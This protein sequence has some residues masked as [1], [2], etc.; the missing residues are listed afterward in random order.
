MSSYGAYG[1]YAQHAYDARKKDPA[2]SSTTTADGAPSRSQTPPIVADSASSETADDFDV[3]L[4]TAVVGQFPPPPIS[5]QTSSVIT[6]H[7]GGSGGSS[8]A[9]SPPIIHYLATAAYGTNYGPT[10]SKSGGSEGEPIVG[11]GKIYGP[12]GWINP[13]RLTIAPSLSAPG[14][15]TKPVVTTEMLT[16]A[17][18]YSSVSVSSMISG[19]TTPSAPPSAG[20][21]SYQP[22]S[23]GSYSPAAAPITDTGAYGVAGDSKSVSGGTASLNEES[24]AAA[25]ARSPSMLAAG[26]AARAYQPIPVAAASEHDR[27]STP[28]LSA[29]LTA[30]NSTSSA[31]DYT[32]GLL[33]EFKSEVLNRDW[34]EHFQTVYETPLRSFDEMC[35]RTTNLNTLSNEFTA[36]A[37]AMAVR[38]VRELP[39]PAA[40]RSIQPI[41][42]QQGVAGGLKFRVGNVFFKYARDSYGLYGGDTPAQKA[43]SNELRALNAVVDCNISE[44]HVTLSTLFSIRGHV[45]MA[46]A[47]CPISGQQSLVY[48]SCDAGKSI[49]NSNQK[50]DCLMNELALRMNLKPHYVSSIVTGQKTVLCSAGD[51]EGHISPKD[52]RMYLIDLARHIAPTPPRAGTADHLWKQFRPEWLRQKITPPLSSDAFSRWGVDSAEQHNS[53]I[54][55]AYAILLNQTIPEFALFIIGTAAVQAKRELNFTAPTNPVPRTLL[56]AA[57]S[58]D[59]KTAPA[60]LSVPTTTTDGCVTSPIVSTLTDPDE[61]PNFYFEFE[62]DLTGQMHARGINLRYFGELLKHIPSVVPTPEKAAGS[63]MLTSIR[64]ITTDVRV[65][66]SVRQL[67][68]RE[69][70]VRS[71][72]VRLRRMHRLMSASYVSDEPYLAAARALLHAVLSALPWKWTSPLAVGASDSVAPPPRAL[73]PISAAIATTAHAWPS[74]SQS[75]PVPKPQVSKPLSKLKASAAAFNP[76][77]SKA[78]ISAAAANAAALNSALPSPT[79]VAPPLPLPPAQNAASYTPLTAQ[80]SQPAPASVTAPAVTPAAEASDGDL[81]WNSQAQIDMKAKY[82]SDWTATAADWRVLRKSLSVRH[83]PLNRSLLVDVAADEAAAAKFDP[84]R[85]KNNRTALTAATMTAGGL[86]IA[87]GAETTDGVT[88]DATAITSTATT[89]SGGALYTATDR[90]SSDVRAWAVNFRK[91]AIRALLNAL[92]LTTS[93]SSQ[94]LVASGPTTPRGGSTTPPIGAVLP[95]PPSDSSDGMCISAELCVF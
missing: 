91:P 4:M 41:A 22:L 76:N 89:G 36:F 58:R 7:S 64:S 2:P 77:A 94:P 79:P 10:D 72:K 73:A 1:A 13:P 74:L 55:T 61:S 19:S 69:M 23:S 70:I 28:P 5:R 46:I 57:G 25:L 63:Y 32:H 48:G 30:T 42:Q 17:Y 84:K 20:A 78:F 16:G 43:A 56:G 44:L 47:I 50:F 33:S 40:R 53:E 9:G 14:S 93:A 21:G 92:S 49:V 3:Q 15:A 37:R 29:P 38:I 39:L 52:R 71:L 83:T 18:A 86:L 12:T 60:A 90:W 81:Y 6:G 8:A 35:S 95:P 62:F 87:T 59:F 31:A 85:L 66:Q 11:R 27:E 68:L 82:G 34:N 75:V 65:L 88:A 54:Q 24:V 51:V 45:I 26:A 80:T 67:I